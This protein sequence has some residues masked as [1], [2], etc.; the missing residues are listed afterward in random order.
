MIKKT[1]VHL[2]HFGTMDYETQRQHLHYN[3]LKLTKCITLNES[4]IHLFQKWTVT[5]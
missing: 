2:E 4:I 5:I 3:F 1:A